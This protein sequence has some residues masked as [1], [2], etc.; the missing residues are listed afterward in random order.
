MTNFTKDLKV[1]ESF[2]ATVTLF[3]Y[4]KLELVTLVSLGL[5][6][7]ESKV[8]SLLVFELEVTRS[9]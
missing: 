6:M 4:V 8:L 9:F 2:Y 1:F 5:F 3:V 7:L